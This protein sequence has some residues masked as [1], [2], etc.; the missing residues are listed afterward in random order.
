MWSAR[1][2]CML[3]MAFDHDRV[4]DGQSMSVSTE[5]GTRRRNCSIFL[6]LALLIFII[7][8]LLGL[9][10]DLMDPLLTLAP[11][12]K[13]DMSEGHEVDD[14]GN[15]L[16]HQVRRSII[17]LGSAGGTFTDEAAE[18]SHEH[19]DEAVEAINAQSV[20]HP[21]NVGAD[22]GGGE[23]DQLSQ[24]LDDVEGSGEANEDLVHCG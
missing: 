4:E 5:L 18:E 16:E 21:G 3:V 17:L 24:P 2:D 23:H 7:R 10:D 13:V 1:M 9:V 22:E 15:N 19:D 11:H 20:V 8:V 12:E 14:E 6:I